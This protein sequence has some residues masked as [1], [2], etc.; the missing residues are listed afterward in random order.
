LLGSLGTMIGKGVIPPDESGLV[1]ITF[2]IDNIPDGGSLKIDGVLFMFADSEFITSDA[3]TTIAAFL[4]SNVKTNGED[5]VVIWNGFVSPSTAGTIYELQ[6]GDKV[7]RI[8]FAISSRGNAPF[9]ALNVFATTT[10][11]IIPRT[12]HM[13]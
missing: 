3:F 4:E 12:R 6:P 2:N 11:T 1:S 7:N 8:L 9:H 13:L 5:R 10:I